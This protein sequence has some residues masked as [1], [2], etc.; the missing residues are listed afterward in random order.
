MARQGFMAPA[1]SHSS[2][3]R[4]VA[5][6]SRTFT[7]HE[8]TVSSLHRIAEANIAVEG[9]RNT[10]GILILRIAVSYPHRTAEANIAGGKAFETREHSSTSA[11]QIHRHVLPPST[12]TVQHKD[13]LQSPLSN[14]HSRTKQRR[15]KAHRSSRCQAS[16]VD[17]FKTRTLAGLHRASDLTHSIFLQ[18]TMYADP[19][20][21]RV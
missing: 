9:L 21:G 6:G 12:V 10:Y 4:D 7:H 14:A 20:A 16:S 19:L 17:A 2:S 3:S 1:P 11:F 8:S 15:W 18:S 13:L 5:A